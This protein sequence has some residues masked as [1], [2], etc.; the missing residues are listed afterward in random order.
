MPGK[1]LHTNVQFW[2]DEGLPGV[3]ARLSTYR[4][5]AFRTHIHAEYS[6]GLIEQGSTRFP[7]GGT[8]HT[9]QAG[10]MVF[11]HPDE[12]HACNP[13]TTSGISY[14]MFYIAPGW[15]A[16]ATAQGRA[17][18]FVRPVVDDPELYAAWRELHEAYVWGAPLGEKQALLLTC[19]REL[20]DRHAD[21]NRPLND[22]GLADCARE[23]QPEL[24]PVAAA[25]PRAKAE[26]VAITRARR[27]LAA[28][29]G[30][31]VP[32]DELAQVAGLSR[33]HFARSFKAA[34]G[35][36]PHSY[37][38][39]LALEH[40]KRL[41]AGGLPI[42]QAALD[43]GFADQSHFSRL[44]RQFTGATPGQYVLNK[45]CDNWPCETRPCDTLPKAAAAL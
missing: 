37:Q 14:R 25:T 30:V 44:F 17:P 6:V 26:S 12:P 13:D 27:H 7:L 38:L 4:K 42:S 35:L 41:L 19:L 11:I 16:G 2:R 31:R 34:T 45:P 20:I 22:T 33:H 24:Q 9:A 10:Q 36:P 39:Q 21:N 29:V 28:S 1:Q 3:E 23:H 32:L 5:H 15:L 40:A 8:M 18:R 43:A